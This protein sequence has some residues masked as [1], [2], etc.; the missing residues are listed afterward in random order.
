MTFD[1][2]LKARLHGVPEQTDFGTRR[3]IVSNQL[4]LFSLAI[5][6]EVYGTVRE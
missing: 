4:L 1:G 5:F 3:R 2:I 6:A